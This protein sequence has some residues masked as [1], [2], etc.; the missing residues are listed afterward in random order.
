MTEVVD[1]VPFLDLASVNGALH[2][3]YELAWKTVLG[4]GRF[5]HRPVVKVAHWVVMVSFALLFL[6]LVTG[7]GQVVDPAF[8]LPL[9]GSFPPLEWVIEAIAWLSLI[10]ILG[11]CADC[12]SDMG[13]RHPDDYAAWKV[14]V[15]ESIGRK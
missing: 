13:L 3:D 15:T 12:I 4:H 9:I 14:E 10:G 5:Q 1:S 11:R 8:T 7:Y 2:S 6:T